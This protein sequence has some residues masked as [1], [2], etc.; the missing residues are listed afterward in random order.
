MMKIAKGFRALMA[1]AIQTDPKVI[2]VANWKELPYTTTSLTASY[3]KTASE[4]IRDTRVES[5][6]MVTKATAQGDV[7]TEFFYG[8]YDDFMAGAAYN[9]WQANVLTFGGDIEKMFAIDRFNKDA[10][11]AHLFL[12][13][14]INT[15]KLS[16]S[17]GQLTGLT[18]GVMARGYENKSDDTRYAVD[19]VNATDLVPASALMVKDFKINGALT[20]GVACVKAFDLEVNNNIQQIACIGDGIF[21]GGL[22]EFKQSTT[23]NLTL[24]YGKQSQAYVNNQVTGNT[25]GI[26]FTVHFEGKGDYVFSLPSIQVTGDVPSG[27]SNDVLDQAFSYSVADTPMTITRKPVT[28]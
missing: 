4:T 27:G 7:G 18:F 8:V 5:K 24:A 19:I 22:A 21:A 1:Y 28:I 10:G 16:I 20:N 6:G 12:G 3:E 13:C 14:A 11:V 9:D 2:P 17:D 23:G 25:I 26:E 15:F